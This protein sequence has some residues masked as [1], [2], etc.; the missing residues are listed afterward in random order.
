MTSS[1]WPR[2]TSI[3]SISPG[4]PTAVLVQPHGRPRPLGPGGSIRQHQ[5]L[6]A[7]YGERGIPVEAN[8]AHHWGMRDAPDVVFV[9]AAYLSAY[10]AR[11]RRGG[12]HRADDVQQPAGHLSD[13]MDLAKTLAAMELVPAGRPGFPHLATDA[14]RPARLS[15]G[16]AAPAPTWPPASTCRWRSP[17]IVH[18]VGY[19]EADHA[20]TPAA[21][22]SS[23]AIWP[24]RPSKALFLQSGSEIRH[25]RMKF[26]PGKLNWFQRLIRCWIAIAI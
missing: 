25:H 22:W 8:E 6:M 11:P 23:P 2:C 26:K 4:P 9:V 7:W 18:V 1:V 19:T 24:V 16:P 17:H 5:E 21:R 12:P 10:N 20:V 14:H 13:A 15:T 3:P